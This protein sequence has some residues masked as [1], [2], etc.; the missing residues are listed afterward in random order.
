MS[1]VK[2]LDVP[3]AD[4]NTRTTLTR[5]AM[6]AVRVTGLAVV[7]GLGAAQSGGATD[8]ES[9]GA[10]GAGSRSAPTCSSHTLRGDYG[11]TIDGQIVG[12]PFAGLLRGLAM[13]HFDGHGNLTQVDFATINGIPTGTEWRPG[14]GTYEVDANCT[15]KAEIEFTDGSPALHLRLVVVD[16]GREVLTIVEG[17]ATGSRGVKVR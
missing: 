15:G 5:R 14:T 2:K 9:V 4:T 17:N 11:F 1:L 13:T 16:G 7:L 12:G 8:D 10:L 6:D 3:T